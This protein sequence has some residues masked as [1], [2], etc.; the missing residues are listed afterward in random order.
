M[1]IAMV[2][3]SGLMLLGMT[4][5][6]AQP[7]AGDRMITV[8]VPTITPQ[9]ETKYSQE[10]GGLEISVAPVDYAVAVKDHVTMQ[11]TTPPMMTVIVGGSRDSVYVDR[12]TYQ[13]ADVQ[14]ARLR[15]LVKINNKMPR[16]FY[17]RG[18]IVQFNAGGRLLAVD[19]SGY[20]MFLGAIVPP[21]QEQQIEIEGPL[22]SSLPGPK[23]IVGI[24]LYDVVTNQ[25]NAG[26]VIEKQNYTWYFDYQM[27]G[28]SVAVKRISQKGYVSMAEYQQHMQQKQIEQIQGIQGRMPVGYVGPMMAPGSR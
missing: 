10:K 1:K 24:F 17:G 13:T 2:V 15:F 3:A 28:K 25:D 20:N 11:P 12:T 6:T 21:R 5:C 4:A 9:P 7:T 18:T 26:T 8:N 16:V 27:E 14:P 19:Q 22:L 23:G